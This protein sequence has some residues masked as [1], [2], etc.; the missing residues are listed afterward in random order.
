MRIVQL[1]FSY[2]VL[3]L[4]C[5]TFYFIN[6]SLSSN[7]FKGVF[8]SILCNAIQKSDKTCLPNLRHFVVLFLISPC[9]ISSAGNI[10]AELSY[11]N[12]GMFVSS[13]AG[14]TWR[15]VRFTPRFSPTDRLTQQFQTLTA[16]VKY[17][18]PAGF[19]EFCCQHCTL[20]RS[21]L[22]RFWGTHQP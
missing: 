1:H 4:L 14:N 22:F 18:H 10:G 7:L 5:S 17:L 21:T 2:T 12:V 20:Q 8:I 15:Q 16:A 9:V 19:I 6:V 3:K 11:N 13:D